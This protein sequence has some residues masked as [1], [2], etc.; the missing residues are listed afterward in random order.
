MNLSVSMNLSNS[1]WCDGIGTARIAANT[2]DAILPSS[3]AEMFFFISRV[4]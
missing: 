4:S 3:S 2:L 1:G